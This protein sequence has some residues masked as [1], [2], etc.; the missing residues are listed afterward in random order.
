MEIKLPLNIPLQY[1]WQRKTA[2][3]ERFLSLAEQDQVQRFYES[4]SLLPIVS[5]D[6]KSLLSLNLLLSLFVI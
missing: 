1:H 3:C 4:L 6:I 5:G 2:E